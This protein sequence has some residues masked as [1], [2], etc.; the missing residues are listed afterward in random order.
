MKPKFGQPTAALIDE[1][2]KDIEDPMYSTAYMTAQDSSEV[3]MIC[4]SLEDEK[5]RPGSPEDWD[6]IVDV[7]FKNES[8]TDLHPGEEPGNV[9][10]GWLG[11][12][13]ST[14]NRLVEALLTA[15]HAALRTGMLPAPMTVLE[16]YQR[17]DK[18]A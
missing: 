2:R 13:W 5:C 1:E 3:V 10:D 6:P 14:V 16:Y 17:V 18:V 8:D 9:G 12:R 11:V 15:R 4:R 7:F